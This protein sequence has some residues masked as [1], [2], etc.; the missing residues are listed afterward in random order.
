MK[1]TSKLV[2][3]GLIAAT[4]AGC[5]TPG[6]RTAIGAGAG[7]AV[8]A[9]LGAIIGNQNGHQAAK[10]AA[11]GAVAGGLLGG[12]IGNYLDKQAKELEQLAETKRT[13]DGIVTTL[14][15]NLLFDSAKAD[16]KPAAVDSVQQIADIIKKY[17]ED[18]VI[19]V[20]YTDDQGSDS[21]NQR[22]SEQRAQAV[23][24]AMINRGIPAASVEP[25]GMGEASPVAAN[26]TAEGRAKNRR[27]ELQISIDQSKVK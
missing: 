20:G 14:K 15:S 17:P 16:L 8:G 27:V 12:G 22:L 24:L 18:K 25:V 10:G 26:T 1:L 13:E 5:A 9:G 19:V 7:A 4:A 2:A 23:R 21:Y 6:K 11:I 3:L